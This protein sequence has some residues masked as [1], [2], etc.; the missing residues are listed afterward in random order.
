[1]E[2]GAAAFGPLSPVLGGE[3]LGEGSSVEL[4]SFALIV[5]VCTTL[6]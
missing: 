1:M 5:R 4:T 3:D 2:L 6:R